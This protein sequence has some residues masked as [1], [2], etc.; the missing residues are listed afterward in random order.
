M[1]AI[2]IACASILVG[3]LGLEQVGAEPRLGAAGL[4]PR[5]ASE[6]LP[7]EFARLERPDDGALLAGR[8]FTLSG[9]DR[10]NIRAMDRPDLSGE[11]RVREDGVLSLPLLGPVPVEGKTIAEVESGLIGSYERII[12]DAINLTIDVVEWRPVTVIGAVD[13]PGNYPIKSE[14]MVVQALA[15]AGGLYRPA[16]GAP[17]AIEV[18]RELSRHKDAANKL[19]RALAREARIRAELADA[20]QVDVPKRLAE[21]ATDEEA[22]TLL[23]GEASLMGERRM[24]HDKKSRALSEQT[25]LLEKEIAALADQSSKIAEQIDLLDQEVSLTADLSTRGLTPRSQMLA[26]QLQRARLQATASEV[27]GLRL[28]AEQSLEAAKRDQELLQPERRVSLRQELRLAE[29]EVAEQDL[30]MRAAGALI[31]RLSE[32]RDGSVDFSGSS[33]K[34][35]YQ[36]T[37]RIAGKMELLDAKET[38]RL[39]PGDVVRVQI[40]K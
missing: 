34:V 25:K 20:T 21:L 16:A 38:T 15:A 10:L 8:P 22:K 37:R 3:S 27:D 35:A 39:E 2:L 33:P 6:V 31:A 24:A 14:M 23:A 36:I 28:R 17:S 29:D 19:K 32:Q 12:R 40:V 5:A 18:M 1:R 7:G 30:A 11:F 13:K 26:R 4:Q 9:G